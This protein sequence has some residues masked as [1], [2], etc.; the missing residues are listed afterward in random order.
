MNFLK[1]HK[2]KLIIGAILII[3]LAAAAP[4]IIAAIGK[5]YTAQETVI[6]T[7]WTTD[8]GE[9]VDQ[10][11]E[12]QIEYAQAVLGDSVRALQ[13]VPMD[14]EEEGFTY[15][16]TEVQGRLEQ[17]LENL[18]GGDMSWTATTPLI[19]LNPYGTGSNGLYL[20]FETDHKT[21]VTYTIHVEDED[22]PDYT[23]LAQ[24]ADGEEFTNV[25]EFQII[26]LVPGE[27]NQVTMEVKGSWGN[28]RQ[29]VSFTVEMPE[30]QSGYA[31]RLETTDGDSGE[32]LSDGLY[33]MMR[34]NGYLG[35]GFSLTTMGS[36]AMRWLWRALAWTVS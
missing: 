3:V 15:Y 31:T 16:D 33:A 28:V 9:I 23:A 2:K 35:Y 13:L 26:G 20:Y 10:D 7:D 25:H 17:A 24:E 34:V 1:K 27:T 36:S 18:K 6:R 5:L 11:E 19:V 8:I 22:I 14:I 21:Q 32:A 29:S 4:T 30:T 12:L